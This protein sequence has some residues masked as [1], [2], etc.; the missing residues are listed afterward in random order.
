MPEEDLGFEGLGTRKSRIPVRTRCRL[1]KTE[2]VRDH[3]E[4][5]RC[6]SEGRLGRDDAG[7]QRGAQ[8]HLQVALAE[9]R[10]DVEAAS[11]AGLRDLG[12]NSPTPLFAGILRMQGIAP[13]LR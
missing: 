8:E 4:V 6:V 10:L 1:V 3:P 11:Y 9:Q 13:I 2:L 7:I 12:H 5:D